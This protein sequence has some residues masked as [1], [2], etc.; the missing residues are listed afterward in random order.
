MI[1]EDLIH[2]NWKRSHL[3]MLARLHGQLNESRQRGLVREIEKAPGFSLP[4]VPIL[5]SAVPLPNRKIKTRRRVI[6]T[7]E[8]A[9]LFVVQPWD[10]V[11]D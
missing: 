3:A 5:V 11:D 10:K 7:D 6:V 8:Q 4:T 9:D 1:L 2:A